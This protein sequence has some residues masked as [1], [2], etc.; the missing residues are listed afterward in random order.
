[1]R[2][3]SPLTPKSRRPIFRTFPSGVR[4]ASPPVGAPRFLAD[5]LAPHAE[6]PPSDLP[7]LP[8]GRAGR[9][10]PGEDLPGFRVLEPHLDPVVV[11][12]SSH[13]EEPAA[14]RR[15]EDP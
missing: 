11:Q 2:S 15:G 6:E 9:L 8:V 14:H 7:D 1:M 3:P 5:P 10:D 13:A 12:V 4:V